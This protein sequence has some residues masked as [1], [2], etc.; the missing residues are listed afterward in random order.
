MILWVS[1]TR[2]KLGQEW[3]VT[4]QKAP[5]SHNSDHREH[6]AVSS[7]VN[8]ALNWPETGTCGCGS[9]FADLLGVVCIAQAL[10]LGGC[11]ASSLLLVLLPFLLE[12]FLGAGVEPRSE[13]P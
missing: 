9:G 12:L 6:L 8:G 5:Q 11:C 7:D 13:D 2:V 1:L 4:A 10:S 3:S